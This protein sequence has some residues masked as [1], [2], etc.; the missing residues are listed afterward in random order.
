MELVR[1]DEIENQIAIEKDISILKKLHAALGSKEFRKQIDGSIKAINKCEKYKIK[2]EIAFGEYYKKLEDK[3]RGGLVKSLDEGTPKQQAEEE[4]GKSRE[5]INKY[6][7]MSS[8]EKTDE[9]L[10]QY[11]IKCNDRGVEMSSMGFIKFA[12]EEQHKD[13]PEINLPEGKYQVFYADPP[14]KYGNTMPIGTTSPT[15]YYPSMSINELCDLPI[16]N[17]ADENAVLFLWVTSPILQE[18]FEVIRT[19]GF[20]Y[21]TSFIWDKIKHNMGHYNSVRHELLLLCVRG[22]Y[23]LQNRKLY[24][25]V[26]SEERTKHS[27]KPDYYYDMIEGLYPNSNKIELFSRNERKGW[28]VY[29]NQL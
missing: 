13:L 6:A 18:C 12:R 15:D 28:K 24:D 22:S 14:W 27:K 21:K 5:T 20:E 17:I 19:W 25:S 16:K 23:P 4:I 11:E 8:I 1:W 3:N 29:G 2:I 7:R 26:Y 10:E 9:L